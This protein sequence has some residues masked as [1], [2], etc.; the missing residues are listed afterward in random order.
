VSTRRSFLRG[1]AAS[2]V[3]AAV[4][5]ALKQVLG[6]VDRRAPEVL[7]GDYTWY[8]QYAHIYSYT[9]NGKAALRKAFQEVAAY[10]GQ[11]ATNRT[12]SGGIKR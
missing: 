1:L 4:A 8:N 3:G 6:E 5:P 9:T 12:Y 7:S 11:Q 2:V 10:G